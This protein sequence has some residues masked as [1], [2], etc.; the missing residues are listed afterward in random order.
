MNLFVTEINSWLRLIPLTTKN[1]FSTEHDDTADGFPGA[2]AGAGAAIQRA[3]STSRPRH[4]SPR[5]PVRP[6][7][8]NTTDSLPHITY[9]DVVCANGFWR[10]ILFCWQDCG[11]LCGFCFWFFYLTVF[12]FIRSCLHTFR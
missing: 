3:R 4:L 1:D 6:T 9:Y 11:F 2:R 10:L 5:T 8:T 7:R 12:F